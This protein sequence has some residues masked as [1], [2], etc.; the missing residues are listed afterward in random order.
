MEIS[1]A[2]NSEPEL[3]IT[4]AFIRSSKRQ[5]KWMIKTIVKTKRARWATYITEKMYQEIEHE[6]SLSDAEDIQCPLW[7]FFSFLAKNVE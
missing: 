3:E 6:S 7:D 5:D 1:S 2:K 4:G